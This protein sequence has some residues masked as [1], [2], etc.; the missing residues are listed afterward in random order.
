MRNEFGEPLTIHPWWREFFAALDDER[1]HEYLLSI[2]RQTGKSQLA[3]VAAVSEL[4]CCPGSYTLCVAASKDQQQAIFNRKIRQPLQR[5]LRTVLDDGQTL[6]QAFGATF[7][8]SGVTCERYGTQLEVVASNEATATG[9]TPSLLI[10]DEARDV[11]DEVYL[12]LAPSVIGAGGKI[13]V[14]SS[15]GRPAGFFYELLQHPT[16]ETWVHRSAVND[17]PRAKKGLL[18]FL[19]RR[20]AL[21]SPVAARRELSNEFAEDGESLLPAGLIDAAVDDR[22]GEVPA[23][24]HSAFAFY[25][26]SRRRDLTTRVVVV[27]EEPRR[28]EAADHLVAASIRVWNPRECPGGETPFDEVRADMKALPDRFPC[29]E[30]IRVDEGAEAGAVLPFA[31]SDARLSLITEGFVA[32]VSSNMQL[33]GALAAR[34]HGQTISVPR[35]D[36]LIAELRG[37][38]KEEFSFGARWRVVDSSRKLHRD[39]SFSL[40]GAVMLAGETERCTFCSDP[41]CSGYHVGSGSGLESLTRDERRVAERILRGA[42]PEPEPDEDDDEGDQAQEGGDDAEVLRQIQEEGAYFGEPWRG[43]RSPRH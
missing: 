1:Y 16:A 35:E 28:P 36:R 11:A 6:Q 14:L 9:R 38:R 42:L 22:L 40:A 2:V 26:L 3:A 43:R 24:E 21:V 41:G 20:L 23:S 34:L 37:L 18:D 10:V 39:L 12:A 19:Q 4:L 27:R 25:D 32:S 5:A 33:W 30:A 31:R 7:T 13:V 15:A 17:N 8:Q 29:I